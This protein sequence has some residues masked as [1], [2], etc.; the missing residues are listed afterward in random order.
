[1][2]FREWFQRNQQNPALNYGSYLD[3]NYPET[4][5]DI[6]AGAINRMTPFRVIDTS[7][8]YGP[9]SGGKCAYCGGT[10]IGGDQ[11]PNCGAPRA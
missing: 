10:S 9:S 1:M 3:H 5:I 2:A 4:Y 6:R 11:C 7:N 8:I